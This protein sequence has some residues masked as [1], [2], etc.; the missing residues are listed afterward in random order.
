MHQRIYNEKE[1][2]YAM[3]ILWGLAA[4]DNKPAAPSFLRPPPFILLPIFILSMLIFNIS[5]HIHFIKIS[6]SILCKQ[7]YK[8]KGAFV[9]PM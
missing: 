9:V 5:V 8:C 3:A 7:S 1:L 2:C 4:M 6:I